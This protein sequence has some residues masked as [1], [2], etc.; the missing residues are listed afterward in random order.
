MSHHLDRGSSRAREQL[1]DDVSSS[2]VPLTRAKPDEY[3]N[4]PMKEKKE[5]WYCRQDFLGTGH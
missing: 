5:Q 4:H 1:C 2:L 3:P